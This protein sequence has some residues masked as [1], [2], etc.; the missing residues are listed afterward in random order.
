MSV[1]RKV[2]Q[3][4]EERKGLKEGANPKTTGDKTT[5]PRQGS[6]KDASFETMGEYESGE[7]ASNKMSKDTT[8][9]AS[10]DA[11]RTSRPRQ[12]DS[13]DASSEDLDSD[14][15][16]KFASRKMSKDSTMTPKISGDKSRP[17]QGD[18]KD[19]SYTEK[20]MA[21]KNMGESYEDEIDEDLIDEIAFELFSEYD[22]E[23]DE[24][25]LQE[26]SK[27]T[28]V[29]YNVKAYGDIS[30]RGDK[31]ILDT[32]DYQKNEKR[33]K[34]MD[35]AVRKMAKEEFEIDEDL[36]DEISSE[37]FDEFGGELDEELIQELSKKTLGNYINKAAYNGGMANFRQGMAVGNA[38]KFSKRPDTYNANKQA[39]IA[40]KREK[41]INTAV[42]KLTKEEM[43][44]QLNSIFGE[45]LTEE[46]KEKA[47]DIFEAAVVSRVNSELDSIIE[48]LETEYEERFDE[49]VSHLEEKFNKYVDYISD[50]WLEENQLSVESGLKNEIME[51]FISDLKVLFEKHNISIPE[52]TVDVVEE[53]AAEVDEL[54]DKLNESIDQIIELNYEIE[55]YRKEN[56][57]NGMCEGLVDTDAD[58]LRKLCEG[59]E[60]ESDES[61]ERKI[62]HVKEQH[63]GKTKTSTIHEDLGK[64]VVSND[65]DTVSKLA[66]QMSQYI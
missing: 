14:E 55:E 12:G 36:L 28:L 31:K 26:L 46:F 44:S 60:Y 63:F 35:T 62:H 9:T 16:G 22:G 42:K 29:S 5:R 47:S 24:S 13:K 6:S 10:T 64:P 4:L 59:I 7:D 58:R 27:K 52:E 53:M 17:R 51:D 49:E 66:R 18:S 41:G 48:Q 3:L 61:F 43:D 2:A 34:G 23:I 56:I 57:L 30:K 19:A 65:N 50:H 1:E 11:D 15:N 40:G 39:R 32:K 37:L 33:R 45:D 8:L 20:N 54:K 38:G 21:S 25:L